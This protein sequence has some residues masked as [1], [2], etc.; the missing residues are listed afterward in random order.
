MTL[1]YGPLAVDAQVCGLVAVA[2]RS[3]GIV[4][5]LVLLLQDLVAPALAVWLQG[6]VPGTRWVVRV[7]LQARRV[8]VTAPNARHVG[9][10]E[11]SERRR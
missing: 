10:D 5:R 4:H 2:V 3:R 1:H 9:P 7:V 8:V 6:E 11:D